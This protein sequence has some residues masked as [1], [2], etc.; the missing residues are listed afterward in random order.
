MSISY[1]NEIG[2]VTIDKEVIKKIASYATKESYGLVGMASRDK[3]TGIVEL[4]NFMNS[5]KGVSIDIDG[6]FVY[7]EL[8]VIVQYGVKV[9][10]VADNLIEKVKYDIENQTDL[11]VKKVTVNVQGVKVSK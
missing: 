9:S 8:F 10:V 1:K 2:K 7:V 3:K 4:L 5:S 6:N 11:K